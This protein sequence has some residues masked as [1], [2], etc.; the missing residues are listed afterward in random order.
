MI[1]IASVLF[2]GSVSRASR[3]NGD[4]EAEQASP[5]CPRPRRRSRRPSRV[6]VLRRCA[7]PVRPGSSEA[8]RVVGWHASEQQIV[9]RRYSARWHTGPCQGRVSR[10]VS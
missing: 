1:I 3:R 6:R 5:S 9:G 4:A 8:G 2:S 7:V 10:E